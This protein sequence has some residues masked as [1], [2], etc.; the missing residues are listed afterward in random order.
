[1]TSESL[2]RKAM[3]TSARSDYVGALI[4]EERRLVLVSVDPNEPW[5]AFRAL[6]REMR[7]ASKPT[8][9]GMFHTETP[10]GHA[11]EVISLDSRKRAG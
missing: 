8:A 7:R 4:E 10:L 6:R 9:I 1:M 3:Q 5:E 11:A 2:R